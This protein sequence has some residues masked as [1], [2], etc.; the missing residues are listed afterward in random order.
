MEMGLFI[1]PE[2]EEEGEEEEATLWCGGRGFTRSKLTFLRE[3]V[4][5]LP[6]WLAG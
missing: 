6:G 4:L 3:L 1:F 5:A 2:Q